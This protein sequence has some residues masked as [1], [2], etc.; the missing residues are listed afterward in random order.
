LDVAVLVSL[1]K[2]IFWMCVMSA[3]KLCQCIVDFSNSS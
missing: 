3:D 2:L 1:K